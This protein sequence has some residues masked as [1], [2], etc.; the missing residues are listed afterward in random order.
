MLR[1]AICASLV[2]CS[3]MLLF[4][5]GV[6]QIVDDDGAGTVA[7]CDAPVAATATVSAAIAA[8]VSGDTVLVCPGTYVE[9][10]NFAG[11]AIVVRSVS[12]PATTILNGNAAGSVVTFSSSETRASVLE[13]FTIRNGFA[14]NWLSHGGGIWIDSASP[15]IRGNVVVGNASGWELAATL[16]A[17]TYH[18]AVYARSYIAQAFNQVTMRAVTVSGSEP[19]VFIDSPIENGSMTQPFT[20]A[21]WAIDL[22]AA[23]GPG[24]DAIHVYAYPNPGSG[25]H[26]VFLGAATYGTPRPD[27]AA[28]FGDAQF[29]NSGYTI[30]ANGLPAGRY[31][32]AAYSHSTVANTFNALQTVTIDVR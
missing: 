3:P 28:A 29:T 23:A 17:G 24:V 6:T 5:Q 21:G 12:G 1:L 16:P 14:G 15:V 27:V 19:R 18:I 4:A 30:T 22:G 9:T 13:G 8:S 10:L 11:K 26:P 25:Q 20:I 31:L 7:S 32:L 2:L